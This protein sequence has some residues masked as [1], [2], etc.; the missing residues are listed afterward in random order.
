MVRYLE[1]VVD[2]VR[3]EDV[4][5]MIGLKGLMISKIFFSRESGDTRHR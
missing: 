5:V 4:S 2:E 3:T 1:D